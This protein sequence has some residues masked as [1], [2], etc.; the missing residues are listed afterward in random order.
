MYKVHSV[1]VL[2]DTTDSLFANLIEELGN[3]QLCWTDRLDYVLLFNQ[4]ENNLH[5]HNVVLLC[6]G[7]LGRMVTV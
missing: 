5:C 2:L 3:S 1:S 4:L 6:V 7:Y